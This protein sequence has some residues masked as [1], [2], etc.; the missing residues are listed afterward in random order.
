MSSSNAYREPEWRT[1]EWSPD[2]KKVARKAFDAALQ[3]ELALVMRKAKAMA[4]KARKPSD[5]WNLENYL[6][7]CRTEI[8][9][10]YNYR[11]SVLP[12]VFGGLLRERKLTQAD[13]SGLGE[14]KIEWIR[15]LAS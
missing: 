1:L 4:E 11:Y 13:F 10:R 7:K 2:E 3:D 15:R 8:D 5:L 6:T 9:R 12:E 14:D